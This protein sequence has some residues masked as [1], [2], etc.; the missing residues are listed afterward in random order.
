M[1]KRIG[2]VVIGWLVALP[3]FAA[4]QIE[5]WQTPKG[6]KVLYAYA[7]ELPMVDVRVVFDAGSARDTDKKGVAYLTNQLIGQ[8]D[9]QRDEERFAEES[10]SLGLQFS[11]QSL[12]DMAVINIRS[13]TR[14]D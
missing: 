5:S 9:A 14:A 10:E 6:A 2:L 1:K 11:T 4:L 3:S 8:G 12:K 7:P 13:L